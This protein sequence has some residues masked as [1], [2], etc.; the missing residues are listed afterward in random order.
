VTLAGGGSTYL[1]F[2]VPA[3]QRALVTVSLNGQAPPADVQLALV[4]YR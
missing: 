1:R 4:R 3:A 2:T